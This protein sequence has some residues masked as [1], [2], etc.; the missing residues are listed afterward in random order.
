M[1]DDGLNETDVNTQKEATKPDP[2]PQVPG[3]PELPK[4]QHYACGTCGRTTVGR[5]GEQLL[6]DNCVNRFL[7]RNV[8]LMRPLDSPEVK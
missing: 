8:G 3:L 2:A 5:V 1:N 7:A 4:M 6:C